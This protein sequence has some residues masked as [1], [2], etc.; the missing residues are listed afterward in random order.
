MVGPIAGAKVT[1]TANMAKPMG[2]CAFGSL[3]STAVKAIGIKTPPA[4]PC[5]PRQT[6]IEPRSWAKEQPIENKANRIVLAN[7]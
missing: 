5:N 2:C 6:I 4:N 7:M 3:V 1:A